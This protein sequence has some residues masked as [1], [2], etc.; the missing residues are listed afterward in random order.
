[1]HVIAAKA[2]CFYE[3]LKPKFICYQKQVLSNI[4]AMSNYFID[5]GV[6]I[7]SGGT[8]NHLIL[9]DVKSSFNITGKEAEQ[10]LDRICITVNKN[11]IPNDT[12][13][14]MKASGIRIGSPAMTTRGFKEDEFILVAQII[15]E[16]LTN[17][18]N[19]KILD[20]LKGKVLKL[21][22]KFP[23]YGG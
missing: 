2:Q 1:M 5:N 6:K 4:K 19:E 12:E 17:Y 14:P 8:D 16:A 13:S 9:V 18:S 11:T 7:V 15:I 10:I 3:A 22:S 21:T 20:E 23:I